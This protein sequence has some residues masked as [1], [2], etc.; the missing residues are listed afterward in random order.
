MHETTARRIWVSLGESVVPPEA[1][2]LAAAA[3]VFLEA[4]GGMITIE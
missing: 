4:L 1:A 2:S 3:A